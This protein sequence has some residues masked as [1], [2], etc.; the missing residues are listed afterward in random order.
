MVENIFH[1]KEASRQIV[2]YTV[3]AVHRPCF[4]FAVTVDVAQTSGFDFF[5]GLNYKPN[6]VPFPG[7]GEL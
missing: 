5:L 2:L 1:I 7:N 6:W 3:P 4:A